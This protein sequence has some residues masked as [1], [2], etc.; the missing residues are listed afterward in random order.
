MNS[1]FDYYLANPVFDRHIPM[2]K[3]NDDYPP[4]QDPVRLCLAS[5]VPEQPR[6]ADYH[7]LDGGVFKRLFFN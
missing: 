5:S 7:D 4:Y 3:D 1:K 2:V 6:M